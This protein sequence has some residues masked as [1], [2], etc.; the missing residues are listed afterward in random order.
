L[1]PGVFFTPTSA[2]RSLVAQQ[3]ICMLLLYLHYRRQS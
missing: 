2:I 1:T 3:F